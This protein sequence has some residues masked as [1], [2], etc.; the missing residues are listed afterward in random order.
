MKKILITGADSY[1]GTFLEKKLQQIPEK[2]TVDTMNMIDPCWKDKNFS[3]YDVVFHVAGI[4]HSDTRKVSEE[5]KKLYY[6]V[7]TDLA[8]ETARKAKTEGVTQFIFMSSIIVYG[9]SGQIGQ[10]KMITADTT[11]KPANFYGDTKFKAEKG[12]IPLADKD[13]KVVIIR[14]P[15]IYGKGCKGNYRILSK[16]AKRLPLFPDIENQRSV[17]YIENL[18]EFIRLMIENDESGIFYPQNSEYLK[19]SELV[20]LIAETHGNRLRLL[21]TFNSLISFFGKSIGMVNK[22]FGNMCYEMK[23]SEYK[24]NYRLFNLYESIERTECD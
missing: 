9:E 18:I 3:S 6:K 13:F 11:P 5:K 14:A 8:V 19:T 21:K 20:K 1:I 24:E 2:Y 17:L 16:Y 4:A 15:M 22:V 12:I 23:M 10:T 7:N